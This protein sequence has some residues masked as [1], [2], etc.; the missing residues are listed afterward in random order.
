ML[1]IVGGL[2]STIYAVPGFQVYIRDAVAGAIGQDEDTWFTFCSSFDLVVAGAY[3]PDTL[4]LTEAT[5]VV[6]VPQGQTGIIL[7]TG[8]GGESAVLL[9]EATLALDDSAYNPSS[10]ADL[11]LLTN[12]AGNVNG[13]DG[14]NDM[15]FL[16]Q[17]FNANNHYPFQESDSNFLLYSIGDFPC[18]PNAVSHYSTEEP[19]EY[20]VA[21]G[22]EKQF[23]VCVSGFTS[24]HFDVYGCELIEKQQG[25]ETSWRMAP[26]SADATYLVPEPMSLL[27]L[28]L[29]GS[30]VRRRRTCNHPSNK[31][32]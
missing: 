22:W 21:D 9:A 18:I 17:G 7:L 12:Q 31:E 28:A 1:A 23:S 19:I 29:G 10:D 6:S 13:H 27:L 26:G 25:I 16:P 11:D 32:L 2:S 5:L 4:D 24:A 15:S 3:G 8:T 14:Y 30:A 20:N